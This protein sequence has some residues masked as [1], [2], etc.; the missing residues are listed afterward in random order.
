[1]WLGSIAPG[2]F[3]NTTMSVLEGISQHPA[4]LTEHNT[5]IMETILPILATLVDSQN[6]QYQSM[7]TS[8]VVLF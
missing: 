4:I 3:V 6:G 1:M 2:E 7:Y 8:L 5:V